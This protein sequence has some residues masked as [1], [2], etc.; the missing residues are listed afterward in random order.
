MRSKS[1]WVVCNGYGCTSIMPN[2]DDYRRGELNDWQKLI[3]VNKPA[4]NER[5]RFAILWA[6]KTF[7][8]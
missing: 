1:F 5:I 4:T 8:L 3:K 6:V 7:R 2:N